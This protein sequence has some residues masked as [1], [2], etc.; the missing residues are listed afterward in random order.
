MTHPEHQTR[1]RKL[2]SGRSVKT[3]LTLASV[4]ILAVGAWLTPRPAHTPPPLTAPQERAAPLLEEQ[5][6]LREARRPFLM[7]QDVAARVREHNLPIAMPALV[8]IPTHSDFTEARPTASDA[9]GTGV[10]VSDNYVL[11]HSL[12]LDGR[13]AVEIE[14]ADGRMVEA[15][16]VAYESSTGLVLLQSEPLGRPS[17]VLADVAPAPGS[18]AVVVGRSD[19]GEA[20][21]PVFVTGVRDGRYAISALVDDIRR[22]MPL[23]NL[24]GELL[25]IAAPYG[26]G[27]LAYPAKDAVARLIARAIA[28]E[29]LTSVGVT[30]QQP[31]GVLADIL[32]DKGVVVTRVVDGG[33]ADQAGLQAGDVLVTIGEV[34]VDG[35]DTARRAMSSLEPGVPATLGVIRGGRDRPIEVTPKLAYEVAALAR[36]GVAEEAQGPE[37]RL[38][39]PAAV[40]EQEGIPPTARVVS[41]NR[42]LVSALTQARRELR[43]A[44]TRSPALALLRHGDDQFFA[45]I[46]GTGQ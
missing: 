14:T 2:L 46:E 7:V 12:T 36:T 35:V 24:E 45:A 16:L 23:Y 29:R 40:L 26:T 31:A 34:D 37:I 5:S 20:V 1:T 42:R 9:A 22:G 28:G 3:Q 17:A 33:P 21:V 13:S 8:T 10:L 4:A 25:A 44:S 41:I 39:L 18:L 6:E 11:A 15:R 38:L 19:G 32:G 43:R 27:V 30:L